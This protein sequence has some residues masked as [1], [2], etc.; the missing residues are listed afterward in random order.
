MLTKS[1]IFPILLQDFYT[2]SHG[3]N[4]MNPEKYIVRLTDVERQTL[5]TI[6]KKLKGTS[7]KVK[8]ATVLFEPEY[9]RKIWV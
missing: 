4:I 5:E 1:L 7:Q 8:R 9:C 3:G 6:V 2:L